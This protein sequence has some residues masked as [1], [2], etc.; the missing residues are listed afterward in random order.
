MYKNI[1]IVDIDGTIAEVSKERLKYLH[2]EKPDWEKFYNECFN[3]KP[4]KEIIKL[5][6]NL[7]ESGYQIIFCTGR[8]ESVREI[9]HEWILSNIYFHRAEP[10]YVLLMR[11]NGD[12]RHDVEVKPELLKE[13]GVNFDN[14]AFVLEDRNSMVK[15]WRELGLKCLQVA[16][17]DF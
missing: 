1:L 12:N 5:V 13:A 3:D 9:T 7:V 16:E 6:E 2:Q 11:K 10:A 4:I 15:K 8:R 14:I 17:G